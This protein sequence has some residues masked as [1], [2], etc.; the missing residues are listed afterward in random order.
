MG[1]S[2]EVDFADVN[3]LAK[4]IYDRDLKDLRPS[5]SILQRRIGWEK[6]TRNIGE[7][8]QIAVCL[9]PPNGFTYAG[10]AGGLV[11]LKQ[12]RNA[13]IK[14]ASITPFE[15][16]LRE[17]LVYAALSR[18][19]KEGEGSFKQLTAATFEAMQKA[20]ANRLEMAMIHGQRGLGTVSSVTDNG[21]NKATI[22][23]TDAS[24]APGM[25]WAIGVGGTLDSFNGT[26]KDNSG[27]PLVVVNIIAASEQVQVSYTGAFGTQIQ[28]NDVIYFEGAWDGT[29]YNELPGLMAQGANTTGTSLGLSGTTYPN[30][31]GNTD[32]VGGN[33]SSDVIE[34][35]VATLRDRGASGKMSAMG[36]NLWFSVL[37]NELKQLRLF[38]DSYSPEK[39][40]QGFKSVSYYSPEV[41]E[42][43]LVN[44]PFFKR[45]E[46]LIINEED[47]ARIGSSDLTFGVPGMDEQLFRLVDGSN[48]VELQLFTDQATVLK[49]PNHTLVATGITYT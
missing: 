19:A 15:M 2:G 32:N 48:A 16:D 7:S 43:E 47:C 40:K 5:S 42:V 1:S 44:H 39:G 24:W 46:H 45:G 23:F 4:R 49:A 30:W 33:V 20:A 6:G 14:Q 17:Q 3:G 37:M 38:D 41:G 13:I 26:S 21:S 31:Q 10:S 35:E 18:A 12:A 8:Y 29:T 9:Q 25:W 11:T 36:S 27:G 22:T 34:T 28:A